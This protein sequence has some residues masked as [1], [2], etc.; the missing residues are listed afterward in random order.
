ML[1]ADETPLSRRV[2]VTSPTKETGVGGIERVVVVAEEELGLAGRFERFFGERAGEAHADEAFG[3][4]I[5]SFERAPVAVAEPLDEGSWLADRLS[6][7]GLVPCAYL[8][9]ASDPALTRE[10]LS[11]RESGEWDGGRVDWLDLPLPG[12][13][14]VLDPDRRA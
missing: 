10:R 6:R 14:G 5:T 9:G 7:F 2:E 3:A 1:V 11:V 13:Y 12:R 8:F 4:R